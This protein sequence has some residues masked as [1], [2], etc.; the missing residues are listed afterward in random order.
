MLGLHAF[1]D[2]LDLK[3]LPTADGMEEFYGAIMPTDHPSVHT[4]HIAISAERWLRSIPFTKRK[5]R[6]FYSHQAHVYLMDSNGLWPH[7]VRSPKTI[8]EMMREACRFQGERDYCGD[9]NVVQ[10]ASLKG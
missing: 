1:R 2:R 5:T 6:F 7:K 8:L 10:Y 9:S 3:P 4:D